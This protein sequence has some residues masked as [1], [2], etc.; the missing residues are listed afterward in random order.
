M[1]KDEISDEGRRERLARW[2]ELGLDQVKADLVN[3][4]GREF[5]GDGKDVLSLAWKWVHE[6]EQAPKPA[7]RD[8]DLIRDLL[9]E[10]EGGTK[11]FH[12][13][14]LDSITRVRV[15]EPEMTTK[16]GEHLHL[17]E[18]AGLI[19]VTAENTILGHVTVRGLTWKGHD[20]LD[21][22]RDPKIWAKTKS[23][24]AAAGGFTVDLLKDLAKGLVKRQIEEYTGVKL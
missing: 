22:I 9:L 11:T 21:S 14:P 17:M 18:T 16:R 12:V 5:I 15:A 24:A 19:E 8:M 20:L 7:K 10:I 23:G 1:S 13:M 3:N 6:K 4:G 2:E